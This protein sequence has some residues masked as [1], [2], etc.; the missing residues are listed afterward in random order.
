[1]VLAGW[2]CLN[3]TTTRDARWFSLKLTHQELPWVF[4]ERAGKNLSS[5]S[6]TVLELLAVLVA[7]SCFFKEDDQSDGGWITATGGTDNDANTAILKKGMMTK[8]PGTFVLMQLA[9]NMSRCKLVLDLQWRPRELNQE[10]DDLTNEKYSDFSLTHRIP[11][12]WSELDLSFL[13]E[14]LQ[15]QDELSNKI[16]EAKETRKRAQLRGLESKKRSKAEKALDKTE[17]G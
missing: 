3:E 8:M 15:M 1:M 10:A 5:H 11:V 13:T 2:E 16:V 17:W 7:V 12:C 6:G 9:L 4:K 14:C